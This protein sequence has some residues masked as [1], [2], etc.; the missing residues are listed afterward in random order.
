MP[1]TVEIRDRVA[2]IVLDHPPVNALDSDGWMELPDHIARAGA[3]PEVR[4]S[5]IHI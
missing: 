2:E 4:L 5:L 3:D 1:I